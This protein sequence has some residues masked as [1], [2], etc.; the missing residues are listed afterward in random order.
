MY[1]K[2]KIGLK[3]LVK[4][5]LS[6]VHLKIIDVYAIKCLAINIDKDILAFHT[7]FIRVLGQYVQDAGLGFQQAGLLRTLRKAHKQRE[8]LR[9]F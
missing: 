6:N 1:V 9:K 2:A 8:K 4:L 7:S 5:T 3:Y